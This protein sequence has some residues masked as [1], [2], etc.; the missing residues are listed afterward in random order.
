MSIEMYDTVTDN[1]PVCGASPLP[2]GECVDSPFYCSL[3]KGHDEP[4]Y[5][6]L[7]DIRP[8]SLTHPPLKEEPH[9]FVWPTPHTETPIGDGS[10]EGNPLK[11][12]I[13]KEGFS[14]GLVADPL[15]AGFQAAAAF[16]N[17]LSTV[18]GQRVVDKIID[19]DEAFVHKVHD[20]FTNIQ[21]FIGKKV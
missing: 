19:F 8:A 15:T 18:Q 2:S 10:L 9:E 12:S 21:N 11:L 16:F 3:A 17:F 14:F 6:D 13:P 5:F 1:K 20:M 4:H 7:K